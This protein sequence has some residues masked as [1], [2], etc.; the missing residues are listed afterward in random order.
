MK[1]SL[2]T[3]DY[4]VM[5]PRSL[6]V[7]LWFDQTCSH[8]HVLFAQRLPVLYLVGVSPARGGWRDAASALLNM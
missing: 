8:L 3:S 2:L 1:M 6:V 5:I 7:A 4:N